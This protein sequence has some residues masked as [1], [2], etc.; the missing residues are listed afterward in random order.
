MQLPDGRWSWPP[1][2]A[3]ACVARP[4]YGHQYILRLIG[5]AKWLGRGERS[6]AEI[7]LHV[8]ESDMSWVTGLIFGSLGGKGGE[9]GR[10]SGTDLLV[11]ELPTGGRMLRVQTT[12]RGTLVVALINSKRQL[13][14]GVPTHV[15][16]PTPPPAPVDDDDD[17]DSD[18]KERPYSVRII[19]YCRGPIARFV[20]AR[21][22]AARRGQSAAGL[23]LPAYFVPGHGGRH[24]ALTPE[25]R[26]GLR[27]GA[28]V[29]VYW[30]KEPMDRRTPHGPP[31]GYGAAPPP[32]API[33]PPTDRAYV[34]DTPATNTGKLDLVWVPTRKDG[35]RMTS[36]WAA[37]RRVYS[38]KCALGTCDCTHAPAQ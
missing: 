20:R 30:R 27:A 21:E 13:H 3:R 10:V 19:P 33:A 16:G 26:R 1:S 15:E 23:P 11:G 38:E 6:D 32:A 22:E 25:E 35:R 31:P 8:D 5:L 14:G 24:K 9:G 2:S 36:T 17:G 34:D 18:D 12:R 29:S 37:G 4:R 7:A 28:G